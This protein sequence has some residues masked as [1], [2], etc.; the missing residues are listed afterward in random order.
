M[1]WAGLGWVG[2]KF[3]G[4]VGLGEEGGWMPITD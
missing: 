4:M 2:R 3:G 1:G